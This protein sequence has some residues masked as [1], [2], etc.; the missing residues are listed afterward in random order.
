MPV[1]N[2]ITK[3][4]FVY[5]YDERGRQTGAVSVGTGKND[6]LTGYTSSNVNIRRGNFIYSYNEKGKQIGAVTAR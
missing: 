4:N 3:G 5:I 6:G 2:A 1:G